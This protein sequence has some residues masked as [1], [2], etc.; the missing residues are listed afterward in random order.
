MTTYS[1]QTRYFVI[2]DAR[3]RLSPNYRFHINTGDY[4]ASLATFM[5]VLSDGLREHIMEGSSPQQK[6]VDLL[7]DLRTD[8]R[9]AQEEY[10]IEPK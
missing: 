3:E 1:I 7:D 8:L 6:Y 4:F 2:R 9:N 10:R 5:C